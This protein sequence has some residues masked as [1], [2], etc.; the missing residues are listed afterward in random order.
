MVHLIRLVR[1]WLRPAAAETS[2]KA[3]DT[4]SMAD[5]VR[6]LGERDSS[7]GAEPQGDRSANDANRPRS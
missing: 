4:S 2:T 3:Q 1:R 6:L 5:L 7:G